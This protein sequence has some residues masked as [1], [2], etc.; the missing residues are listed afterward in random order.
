L[1]RDIEEKDMIAGEVERLNNLVA[2]MV[3]ERV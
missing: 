1:Q 3:R 2:K